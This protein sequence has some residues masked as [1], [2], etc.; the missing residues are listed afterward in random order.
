MARAGINQILV[1]LPQQQT[2]DLKH[3]VRDLDVQ[4][5]F[6][7]WGGHTSSTFDVDQ[8]VLLVEG[9]Y[10]H[11]HSALSA[12]TTANLQGADLVAQVS[13]LA[14]SQHH[15]LRPSDEGPTFNRIKLSATQIS[16]GAFLC[17]PHLFST[18]ALIGKSV[19]IWTFI[20]Q[21]LAGQNSRNEEIPPHLWS[22]ATDKQGARA[23]KKMLFDQVSKSTSGT[24]ARL[25]NVR[26]SVPFSKMIV[27]TGISP[28]MVTFFLVLCPGLLGAYLVTRPD[29]YLRIVLAGGLWQLASILDG[30]DGEI[31]RVKLGETK[32]GAWFD[33]VTDNF[34]YICG[35]ICM[36]LGMQ[37]LYPDSRFAL[38]AGISS[39]ASMILT[40]CLLYLYAL[41]TNTG[42]LQ[43]YLGDL[44]HKIPEHEKDWSYRLLERFGFVA[45]RDFLSLFIAIGMV[46]NQFEAIYWLLTG[47]VH[48]ATLAVLTTHYR[49]IKIQEGD[50]ASETQSQ[51][52]PTRP[53]AGKREEIA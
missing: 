30:C 26:I 31:A 35:Y 9:H 43:Y 19:D 39:I 18:S 33:T 51:G 32:F 47:L 28:N 52:I 41:R 29:D 10:V 25:I 7:T 42:S 23:A 8:P 36:I 21:S 17:A 34:A 37:W 5:E 2:A 38:F 45:K 53:T 6:T 46:A 22:M 48:L 3:C 44:A 40:L 12:L 13:D 14:H 4:I 20:D 16:S 49:L 11:H 1:V 24:V 50:A 15:R 27:D